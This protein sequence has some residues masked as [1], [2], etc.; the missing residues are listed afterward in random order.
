MCAMYPSFVVLGVLFV[1]YFYFLEDVII[2]T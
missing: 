2:G 1:F